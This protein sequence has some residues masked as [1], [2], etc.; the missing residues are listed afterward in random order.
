M[1]VGRVEVIRCLF[2]REKFRHP[3]VLRLKWI[4]GSLLPKDFSWP[5]IS[6]HQLLHPDLSGR[7][8]TRPDIV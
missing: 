5:R 7:K 2:A 6:R 4:Q 8:H 1:D 3:D